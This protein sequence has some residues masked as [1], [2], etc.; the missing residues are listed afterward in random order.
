MSRRDAVYARQSVEKKDSL[1]ISGQVDLCRRMA[2][3]KELAVY[4]DV[5][6]SGK[7]TDRPAFRQ[8]MRDVKAGR[9]ATLYVYRLDRFSR[10]VADFG[11]LW[12][13]L[14]AN[15]VE[16]VSV[17]ENFDTSTPMGRAMLHIIMVFAQLERETT[18]QR[19]RDNYY[20]RAALGAWPGGPAPFGFDNGR[21]AGRD[22]R[23]APAL[24][25]N[26]HG[27]LVRRIFAEYVGEGTSLSGLA[28]KLSREGIP[29]PKRAV[30]D[31]VTLSRLLH[32]PAYVKADE[33][34]RLYYLG[35]GIT[36]TDPAEYF[37]GQHGLLLVG[38][39]E[40]D[41]RR[42]TGEGSQVLSVLNSPGLVE[43]EL[44][45]RCQEKL[46]KNRQLGRSGQGKH[47]WLSGLLKCAECGY[48][49]SVT[50]SGGR[51][52]LHCSGRYNL[53]HCRLAI[54][55]DLGE[56][57]ERVQG[58][59]E[60]LLDSCPK[61]R[62]E[63]CG[64]SRYAASLVELDRQ[65]ERLTDAFARSESMPAAYLRRALEKI[66]RERQ[67]LQQERERGERREERLREIRLADLPFDGKKAVAAQLIGCIRLAGD[68]AEIRWTV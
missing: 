58:D 8:L 42:R 41:S 4:R 68:A 25:P 9:I 62:E 21:A 32:N 63:E 37:D 20:R 17:S 53:A 7:N 18:A 59:M 56:L 19:V 12:Q 1:S 60:K 54:R 22:G 51:R 27:E 23:W 3:E 14:Q 55:V 2:G 28:K 36:V 38:R 16:F 43:A 47:T 45:L 66:G 13:V 6:Y 46:R 50:E 24:V 33:Q 15:R 67:T 48:S 31:S 34:V 65:A 49:V 61:P 30:W 40:P 39:R 57:E 26:G 64:E 35:Q 5:G 44:F 10:S 11:Q 52:Y 29:G